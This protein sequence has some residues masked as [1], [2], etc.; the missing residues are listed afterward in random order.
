M[1]WKKLLTLKHLRMLQAISESGSLANA[2]DKLN[3]SPP[4]VTV[5]L[6]QLEHYLDV[7]IVNRGPN[8][9]ISI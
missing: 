7:R 2:A 3:L 1:E 5:Q 6:N 8:G 4:A 9:R